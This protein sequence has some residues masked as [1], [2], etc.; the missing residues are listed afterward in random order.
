MYAYFFAW[1]NTAL[2]LVLLINYLSFPSCRFTKNA[3]ENYYVD[4]YS[5]KQ[6]RVRLRREMLNVNFEDILSNYP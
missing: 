5:A 1:A 4:N 3:R 6:R 2:Y